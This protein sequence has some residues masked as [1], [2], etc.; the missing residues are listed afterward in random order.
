[1]AA[2][3]QN[4]IEQ[5]MRRDNHPVAPLPAPPLRQDTSDDSA[6]ER[7]IKLQLPTFDGGVDS[8]QAE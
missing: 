4:I 8:I 2:L 6:G 7:F 1:M 3:V 5:S